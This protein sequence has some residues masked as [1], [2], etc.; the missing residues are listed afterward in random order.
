LIAALQRPEVAP[1]KMTVG[2]RI[3]KWIA[4]GALGRRRKKVNPPHAHY[5]EKLRVHVM[6]T[7]GKRLLEQLQA[8]ENDALYIALDG[9]M[10]PTTVHHVH[11]ILNACLD[12]AV[13]Q[14]RIPANP[15]MW[16]E[17]IP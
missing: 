3:D 11:T 13:R 10:S 16:C 9:K 7:L 14:R 1:D 8:T 12:A 6:P 4:A 15:I 17:K 2:Q 5:E